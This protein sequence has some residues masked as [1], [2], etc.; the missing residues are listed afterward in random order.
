MGFDYLSEG[1]PG[2]P[3]QQPPNS[4]ALALDTVNDVLYVS[5]KPSATQPA[6]WVPVSASTPTLAVNAQ[7]GTTYAIQNSDLNKLIT[8]NNSSPVA[9]T[10]AQAGTN[11]NFA[12]GWFCFVNNTGT[13]IVTITPTT[14]T[15]QGMTNLRLGIN[16]SATIISDGVNYDAQMCQVASTDPASA[17]SSYLTTD[18]GP[19]NGT[20]EIV[21]R[22]FTA[23]NTKRKGL[24]VYL[25]H[26][27]SIA[28]VNY[29]GLQVNTGF[30]ADGNTQAPGNQGQT[31][32]A[33]FSLWATGNSQTINE[34]NGVKI[35]MGL[36]NSNGSPTVTNMSGLLF[37]LPVIVGNVANF[38][39]INLDTP[40]GGGTVTNYVGL[41]MVLNT[42]SITATNTIG[43]MFGPGN[44]SGVSAS[45][46]CDDSS[47]GKPLVAF[48][49][50]AA[51]TVHCGIYSGTGSPAGVVTANVGSLYLR[52]DGG[53]GTTLYVKES[54]SGNT[55]WAS[56]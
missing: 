24:N 20:N 19:G 37:Y 46:M 29:N 49:S 3:G 5:T 51:P 7:T 15:I 8:F 43:G 18:A 53:A 30:T 27:G 42:S 54:G 56:K 47:S 45:V 48:G 17:L 28:N 32:S 31:D 35:R 13:G 21:V 33:E 26:D 23:S 55:G 12:S 11:S 52:Q 40:S 1:P 6:A 16:Q 34:L 22:N 4:P 38:S 9:V 50:T 2:P 25:E 36:S 10:I 39:A 14:S 44:G 41:N